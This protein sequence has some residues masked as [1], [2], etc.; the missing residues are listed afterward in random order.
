MK[1][2]RKINHV[3][4]IKSL[5]LVLGMVM[6][7]LP[8]TAFAEETEDSANTSDGTHVLNKSNNWDISDELI[9]PGE[10][11]YIEP[12]YIVEHY[13]LT[14]G[15]TDIGASIMLSNASFIPGEVYV[16]KYGESTGTAGIGG[17]GLEPI[18][19]NCNIIKMAYEKGDLS[20]VFQNASSD[21]KHA[22]DIAL[23][24]ASVTLTT[25]YVNRSNTPI[26]LRYMNRSSTMD[27]GDVYG[28]EFGMTLLVMANYTQRSDFDFIS[29]EP[30]YT[31]TYEGL[32]LGE[33]E[34]LPDRYYVQNEKQ[35]L[36]LTNP[37]RPG[38]HFVEWRG[39]GFADQSK[40]GGIICV[41]ICLETKF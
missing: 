28:G 11:F 19:S 24:E 39:I 34:G 4:R 31:L 29:Y 16:T 8:T 21:A 25:G 15:S 1:K 36:T 35:K 37:V 23:Q 38:Y 32:L 17:G 5:L 33:E 18:T 7:R 12:E 30:Y 40:T 22:L 26:T 3:G 27:A 41:V 13:P 20:G 9:M 14:A 10:S 6:A 2:N